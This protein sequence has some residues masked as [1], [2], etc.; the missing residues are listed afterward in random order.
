MRYESTMKQ[1]APNNMSQG[2]IMKLCFKTNT[3]ENNRGINK[4]FEGIVT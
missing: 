4:K 2:G 1:K 3:L